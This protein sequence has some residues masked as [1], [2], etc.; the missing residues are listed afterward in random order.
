MF[1]DAGRGRTCI[2]IRHGLFVCLLRMFSV[3]LLKSAFFVCLSCAWL[4]IAVC[5]IYTYSLVKLS[6][7]LLCILRTATMLLM[8]MLIAFI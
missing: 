7:N 5:R 4:F 3:V 2:F 1:N 6:F 8:L